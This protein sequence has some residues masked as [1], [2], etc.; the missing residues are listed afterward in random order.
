MNIRAPSASF[1]QAFPALED[2]KVRSASR[3][4][5]D[6]QLETKFYVS[7]MHC[8]GC[9]RKI[10]NEIG[11]LSWVNDVRANLSLKQVQI[12][13]DATTGRGSQLEEQLRGLGFEPAL[14]HTTT[15]PEPH[16]QTLQHLFIGL[17]VAG[18]AAANV[19]LL[20]VSI[21]SGADAATRQLFHLISGIIAV[22]AAVYAGRPFFSSAANA[23]I[24]GRLNMDVPISLAVILALGMSVFESL[25]G[26]EHAYFDAA[27]MLLFFLLIGRTLD[28]MMR[29][30]A[31]EAVKTLASLSAKGAVEV[32]SDGSRRYVNVNQIQPGSH[33]HV[34]A[35]ERI[36]IDGVVRIG[37]SDLDRALVT[38]E[39]TSVPVREGSSVEG[40][41]INLTGPLEIEVTKP[42]NESFLAEVIDMMAAAENSKAR[43]VRIADRAAQ[44]YAPTVHVLAL[45]TFAGWMLTSNGD[46]QAAGYTAIAVLIITCPC[47]LGLAV[48][49]V[50]VVGA[51]RLFQRGI[52]M[53]DGGGFEKLAKIDFAAFDKTGTLTIG[54]PKVVEH[55]ATSRQLSLAGTIASDSRHPAA[56]SVARITSSMAGTQR[57]TD[58]HEQ[59][60]LGVEGIIDG[61]RV[62]LGRRSW[63]SEATDEQYPGA[64]VMSVWFAEQNGPLACFML[65]DE[66]RP[67]AAQTINE[68][69]Q[70]SVRTEI[71]SGDSQNVVDAL[72]A[73]LNVDGYQATM[74]PRE[75]IDHI[76]SL[77][78]SGHR[79]LMVGDG[80]NDAPALA[81]ADVS[82]APSSASDVGQQAADF[83]FTGKSLEAVTFALQTA[84]RTDQLIKQ[85]IALAVIYNCF[86]VPLAV[87]GYVTPLIAAAAMSLSSIAVIGNSLRLN[88]ENWRLP[89]RRHQGVNKAVIKEADQSS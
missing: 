60:G 83:V 4:L 32:L 20:S 59:P 44:F 41:T 78:R 87:F 3:I 51:A 25:N 49:I 56:Q 80:L 63:V 9:L 14:L 17:G 16:E 15:T 58:V 76:Q 19:M 21:W 65:E 46:W 7:G 50:H 12:R 70:S 84:R 31:R 55:N 45:L 29:E 66:L 34:A 10:E 26:G 81:S 53:K 77:Q 24:H 23:L 30:R 18:F 37:S 79:V 72:A 38:G 42:A 6:A 67:D 22:P 28:F 75:K 85:N 48:P 52:L 36:P 1:S 13:W 54:Q 74:T 47:A 61:R 2:E 68:L 82:I 35:G 69:R 39:S 43:F 89:S 71:L 5:D 33:V 40:G 73:K 57:A 11:K 86:A 62:R 27:V 64:S 8:A 88:I